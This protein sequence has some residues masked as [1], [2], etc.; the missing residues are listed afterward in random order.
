MKKVLIILLMAISV[1]LQAQTVRVAA[2]GNLRYILDEIKEKYAKVSP[3]ATIVV[4]LGS[5]GALVQQITNGADFDLFMAADII[6]PEKLKA[7][8]MVKGDIKTYAFGKLVLWSNTV[9]V[10]KG[11]DIITDK[12]VNRIAIAKPDV[13]P[14]GARAIECLKYYKLYDK[15]KEKIVYADN[16]AQAAQ[17]AQTG[18]AE[19]GFIALALALAPDMKG[20]YFVLDTKSYKPVEQAM[21]QLKSWQ[22]NPETAKFMKF[23][24]SANCKPI[25]EKYGFIV[26]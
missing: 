15:V 18:N 6:Y 5:S 25:F 19:I 12:S 9:D 2:A 8:G 17:F 10:S 14:Y 22:A 23:V 16:I 26:P 21:V 20:S 11:L 13:A 4:N 3:K 24:L 7:Q 1:G